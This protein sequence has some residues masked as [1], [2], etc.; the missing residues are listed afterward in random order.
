MNDCTGAGNLYETLVML[1]LKEWEEI[2]R[3]RPA[4]QKQ[5]EIAHQSMKGEHL[6][7]TRQILSVGKRKRLK[8]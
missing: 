5:E 8:L 2:C 1:G 6:S 3:T 7:E 4:R